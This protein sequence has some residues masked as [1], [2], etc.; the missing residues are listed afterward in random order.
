MAKAIPEGMHSV[1]PALTVEG[2][3]DA[4][5]FWKKAFGAIEMSRALDPSGQ[6]VWHASLRIGDSVVFAND[7]FPEMG[8]PANKTRLWIYSDNADAAYKRAVDAGCQV[9]M[10]IADMFW[11]D[12]LGTVVDRW[13]NEWTLATRVKDLTPEEMKKAQDAFVAGMK[14]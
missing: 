4:I 3:A 10:A 6:K 5:E 7:A 8:G 13:G 2:A 9:K 1:T 14:R 11:G 12:R